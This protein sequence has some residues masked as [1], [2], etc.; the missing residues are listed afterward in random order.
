MLRI[1]LLL[2]FLFVSTARMLPAQNISMEETLKYINRKLGGS[3]TIDVVRGIIIAKY[4][5]NG[6]LIRE[7]QVLCKS[8][9]INSMNYDNKNR[10]FSINCNNKSDC[11]DRQIYHRRI[12]RDYKR[13]SFPVSLDEKGIQGMKKAFN[14]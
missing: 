10:I 4:N 9:D 3:S 2:L 1:S 11:V 5:K 6:E 8:L 7:D 14:T 12:Q 13:L